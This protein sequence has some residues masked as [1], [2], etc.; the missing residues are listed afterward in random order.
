MCKDT[1]VKASVSGELFNGSM[2]K[3]TNNY[4]SSTRSGEP[5]PDFYSPSDSPDIL[6]VLDKKFKLQIGNKQ[7]RLLTN[8]KLEHKNRGK[9]IYDAKPDNKTVELSDLPEGEYLWSYKIEFE[10][11]DV[12]KTQTLGNVFL[13]PSDGQRAQMLSDYNNV[14]KELAENLNRKRISKDLYDILLSEYKEKKK[15]F[16]TE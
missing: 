2:Q 13:I 5:E 8:I 16:I 14:K 7:T 6:Y 10:K 12:I 15:I 1:P 3:I 4:G 9:I 11:D